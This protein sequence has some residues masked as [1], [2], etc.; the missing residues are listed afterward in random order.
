YVWF[1]SPSKSGAQPAG[2]RSKNAENELTMLALSYRVIPH[3]TTT[4][5]QTPGYANTTCYGDGTTSGYLSTINVNCQTVSSPTQNIPLTISSVEV[6]NQLESNGM[7]YTIR[8]T[9]NWIGS[10]CCWLK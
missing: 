10:K 4:Y 7:I 2:G 1:L 5:Y 8:C 9:A 3:Q 6:F